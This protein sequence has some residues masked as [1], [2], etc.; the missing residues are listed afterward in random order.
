MSSF[1]FCSIRDFTNRGVQNAET[2]NRFSQKHGD[3]KRGR[4]KRPSLPAAAAADDNDD[5]DDAADADDDDAADDDAADD[6]AAD[7]VAA[8]DVDLYGISCSL[9]SPLA[10]IERGKENG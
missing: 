6:D 9:P 2:V 10:C 8:G 4:T 3:T 7:G 1:A 5:A